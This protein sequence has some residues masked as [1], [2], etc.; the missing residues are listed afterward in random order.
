MQGEGDCRLCRS[1]LR[2]ECSSKKALRR[3]MG[4]PE[5][6][7]PIRRVPW[8]AEMASLWYPTKLSHWVAAARRSVSTVWSWSRSEDAAAGGCRPVKF[9]TIGFLGGRSEWLN[10]TTA[11]R[12]QI[13]CA[14][15]RE[16]LTQ[17]KVLGK[18]H[19][20]MRWEL[21]VEEWVILANLAQKSPPPVDKD[22]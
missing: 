21:G 13:R 19:G 4:S 20:G 18:P 17:K 3:L 1:C 12:I 11:A 8:W 9:L 6:S 7:F 10:S 14:G 2:L 5:Q 22:A 16:E 15:N